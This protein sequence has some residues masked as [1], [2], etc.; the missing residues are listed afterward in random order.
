M[1][2]EVMNWIKDFVI[3]NPVGATDPKS[4]GDDHIRGIKR[5][6]LANLPNLGE[7]AVKLTG[8]QL[9]SFTGMIAPF[10]GIIASDSNTGWLDCDGSAVLK[11]FLPD[12]YAVIGDTYGVG[13]GLG[14]EFNLPDYRGKFLRCQDQGAG[15][16]PGAALR[17]DYAGATVGDVVGSEQDGSNEAHV[18]GVTDPQHTHGLVCYPQGGNDSSNPIGSTGTP[19]SGTATTNGSATGITI[20]EQ[21]AAPES[22][23]INVYVR[24]M[25]HI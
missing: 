7:T 3:T 24:Y 9:N 21:G 2:L 22:R 13:D 5:G 25:I 12:L 15:V 16:D 4:E 17:L 18:H 23:P 11:D 20:D 1:P 14:A 6:V 8:S 19:T 10:A